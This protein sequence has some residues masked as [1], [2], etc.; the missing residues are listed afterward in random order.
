MVDEADVPEDASEAAE[1]AGVATE[2][3]AP[4]LTREEAEPL[5]QATLEGLS[6]QEM[7]ELEEAAAEAGPVTRGARAARLSPNFVLAEFHC[8]R[9]HCAMASVPSDA[10]PAL[11]RLVRQVLQPMR[12][13]FGL[14]TVHS[15]YRNA[16]HNGH[17]GGAPGSHHRY[18]EKPEAPA[19]DVSFASGS[20]EEWARMARRRLRQLGA[21]GG[22]GRY[23]GSGFVHIDLGSE[24]RWTG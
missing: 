21:I 9:G 13:Q 18:D 5:D 19:A 11:R 15:G 16:A 3:D 2:M 10:V 20:V 12:D 14:C 22:I 8:C 1:V 6:D 17:V 4:K 7:R 24:R 23:H